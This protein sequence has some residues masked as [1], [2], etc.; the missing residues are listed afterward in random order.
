MHG[1]IMPM[2]DEILHTAHN[3]K[4]RELEIPIA[5]ILT[6]LSQKLMRTRTMS[7]FGLGSHMEG[8]CP[9]C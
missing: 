2:A 1:V 5:V 3:Q 7:P 8:H 9:R 6:P 4:L